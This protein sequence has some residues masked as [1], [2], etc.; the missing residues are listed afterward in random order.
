MSRLID[1]QAAKRHCSSESGASTDVCHVSKEMINDFE[2]SKKGFEK[3][4]INHMSSR[5]LDLGVP[6]LYFECIGFAMPMVNAPDQIFAD[7]NSERS[8]QTILTQSLCWR[9][10]LSWCVTEIVRLVSAPRLL[11]AHSHSSAG[12]HETRGFT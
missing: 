2:F 9:P 12:R 8:V 6:S 7:S 1:S 5:E 11:C 10:V 3:D 4:T